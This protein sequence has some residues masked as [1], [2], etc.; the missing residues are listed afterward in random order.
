MLPSIMGDCAEKQTRK[1]RVSSGNWFIKDGVTA[2]P[3]SKIAVA[4]KESKAGNWEAQLKSW[5]NFS[6]FYSFQLLLHGVA[7]LSCD[8]KDLFHTEPMFMEVHTDF[9]ENL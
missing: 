1:V 7:F 6:W 9:S 4:G 2:Y 5:E 3:R 8:L